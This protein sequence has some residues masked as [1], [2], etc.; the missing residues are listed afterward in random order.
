MLMLVTMQEW[1]GK[2]AEPSKRRVV[3]GLKFI[4]ILCL[5]AGLFWIIPLADV[6]QVIKSANSFLLVIG[7]TLGLPNIY[8]NSARLGMLTRKQGLAITINR[9]F[10]VNLMVKF[11]LLFLP[12]TLVGSGIRWAKISPSGKS[13]ETLAAIA[14]NRFIEIFLIIITGIFW[15]VAGSDQ[16]VVRDRDTVRVAAEIGQHGLRPAEGWLGVDDP[17]GFAQR[18]E[19]GG[20][21]VRIGQLRP[22]RR[23]SQLAC[24]VQSDQP[25]EEQ[26]TEQPRQ[27]LHR[28]EEPRAAA[29]PPGAIQRQPAAWHDDMDMRVMGHR[30]SPCVQHRCHA[31]PGAKMLRIGGDGQQRLGRC[32]EQQTIDRRLV[33]IRDIRD[34]R[35]QREDHMEVLDRQQVLDARLHPFPRRGPLAL[36]AMPVAA[37]VVG[38]VLV[39]ALGA[40]R[41]MAAER[42]GPAS[43]DRGHHLQLRQVQMPGVLMAIGRPMGAEDIRDLQFGAGHRDRD[44][45][46]PAS[47]RTSRSSGL[48]TFWIVLVATLV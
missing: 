34:R 8:L 12:G 43:L 42:G 1:L 21:G 6:L 40:G 46:E 18:R 48:V 16:A 7:I 19:M 20:E 36:R 25:F 9:L 14:F 27:D 35:R 2:D 28:Q 29:D 3:Q 5:F 37:R 10:I 26:A 13:A 4:F 32:L 30:R 24:L 39:T 38:D 22:D 41:H 33:L 15:F 44:Q 23:R 11:Y 17:F 45:P 47:R 31:D